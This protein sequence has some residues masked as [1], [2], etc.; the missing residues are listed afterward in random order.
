MTYIRADLYNASVG[1]Y[2]HGVDVGRRLYFESKKYAGQANQHVQKGIEFVTQLYREQ[3]KKHWPTVKPHFDEHVVGNY[4]KHVEPHVQ[5]HVHPKMKQLSTWFRQEFI[6]LAENFSK[7][8]Q[9]QYAKFIALYGEQCNATLKQFRKACRNN[10][11]LKEHPPPKSLMKM[12]GDSCS[13]PK[14]SLELAF[15]GLLL[16]LGLLFY[17]RI[18]RLV[19]WMLSWVAS[20]ILILTPLGLVIS[21]RELFSNKNAPPTTQAPSDGTSKQQKRQPVPDR[22]PSSKNSNG[23]T[24]RSKRD[25]AATKKTT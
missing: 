13:H 18:L 14:E 17:R 24:S 8:G 20:L 6:P 11:F 2:Y 3:M 9:K 25:G 5:K 12:W 15:Q 21:R 23:V 19:V 10:D 4:R 16:L 1:A 7:K 22:A